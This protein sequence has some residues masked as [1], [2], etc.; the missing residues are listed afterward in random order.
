MLT[1]SRWKLILVALAIVFGLMFALPNA[2]SPK[3]REGLP[4]FLPRQTLNLG[5]DLQGGSYLLLEVDTNALRNERLTNM[6]EDVRTQLGEKKIAFSGLAV[7]G[8]AVVLR[9]T[10]PNDIPAATRR[11]GRQGGGA[12]AGDHPPTD[13]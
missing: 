13:R 4:G 5:L 2:L 6:V 10:D 12:V 3:A 8:G 9:I 1:L 11:R 7:V